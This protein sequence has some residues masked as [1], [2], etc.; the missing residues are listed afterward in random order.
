LESQEK[1]YTQVVEGPNAL[2]SMQVDDLPYKMLF[3]KGPFI[4]FLISAKT[5][6][7]VDVSQAA[8]VLYGRTVDEMTGNCFFQLHPDPQGVLREKIL[9]SGDDGASQ[10]VMKLAW[11]DRQIKD[12]E[13]VAERMDLG[14]GPLIYISVQDVTKSLQAGELL[15]QQHEML[16]STL[17]SIDDLFFT[18]NKHGEFTEYY[19]PGNTNQLSLSS[20]LFIGKSIRDVG[21]P[22]EVAEKYLQAID[23]VLETGRTEQ[24]EYYLD[25]FGSR[26]WYHAKV[27]PRRN[28]LNIA[29]G[30]T[31]LCRDVTRQKKT[32]ET[33]IRARDFYLTLFNDFP[34][35]IWK[36]NASKKADYFNKTWLE[37]T[38]RSLED[39]IATGW[40]E[41]IHFDDAPRFL[42]VLSEAYH[43]KKP[44]QLEHRLLDKNGNYRWV[45]NVG[46]PFNNLDGQFAGFIGSSYDITERRN[47]EDMLRIQRSALESALEGML[48]IDAQ[49]N[50]N[51]VIY[52]NKELS[53][54]TGIDLSQINGM[55]FLD[56]IG[57]PM[58]A[59][60][61]ASIQDAIS[62][63]QNFKGEFFCVNGQGKE[64]WRT[65][66][67]AP[68]RDRRGSVAHFVV[69]L[70]DITESKISEKILME[71]N[72]ELE[73]TNSE[74]D[75]FVYSTSHELRSP[76]MSVLGLINLLEMESE[77]PEQVRY[78]QMMKESINKL[79]QILHD[80]IDYSQNSRF[81]V[82][83]EQMF[84]QPA[85][86]RIINNLRY[87]PGAEKIK[88]DVQVDDI[89]P[90]FSDS[91]R[92]E[93]ILNNFISNA[94]KF[95]N[96]AKEVPTIQVKVVTQAEKAFI[97]VKDNG[98]GISEAHMPRIYDMF[99]RGTEKSNGSGIGLYI[100]KEIV[101][102]LQGDIR[103][104]ST[105]GQGTEFIVELPNQ[106]QH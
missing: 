69:V 21:F 66:L 71:K 76:L 56:V 81:E 87:M 77:N 94:I 24:I 89:Q 18:M 75:S 55:N 42:S 31:V 6:A 84:F 9:N 20:D 15:H 58:T 90:F 51:P 102:K 57:A 105:E 95:H 72:R 73:K 91:R 54:I 46:R 12:L 100:V 50:G 34:S 74:L 85:V 86:E 92:V 32:E 47:S 17:S 53:K 103:V 80:I 101:E 7:I 96:T 36:T 65:L 35:L 64:S 3:R 104:Q 79:D 67:I 70:A 99:F 106:I 1:K 44:F 49:H 52:A 39:E 5:G 29:D 41:K 8:T 82:D 19:Q 14:G 98:S 60:I 23:R 30:V 28:S 11:D 59:S 16:R 25:A 27:T 4:Q 13:F 45:I 78:V 38:G 33:L 93:I 26:L 43:Q 61:T 22:E 68:V 88:F 40:M 62:K 10:F 63:E 48:I 83:S 2:I 97:T 37:F